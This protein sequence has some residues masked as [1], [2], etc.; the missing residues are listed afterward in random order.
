[1]NTEDYFHETAEWDGEAQR[2][3]FFAVCPIC[4]K[5]F[6]QPDGLDAEVEARCAAHLD[7]HTVIEALDA[8]KNHQAEQRRLKEALK[9]ELRRLE[10]AL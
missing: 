4:A 7:S 9:T 10:N 6:A 1:M 3:K 2:F 8:L 5:S